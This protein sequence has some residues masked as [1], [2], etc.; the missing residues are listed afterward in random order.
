MPKVSEEHRNAR[1]E[2]ITQAALSCFQQYGYDGTSMSQIIKASGLSA[3]AIYSYF[4]SKADI[5]QAV[6]ESIIAS[7]QQGLA[8]LTSGDIK[9]PADIMRSLLEALDTGAAAP[10]L[11]QLWSQAV[12]DD[13]IR[14][15]VDR[16]IDDL[17]DIVSEALERWAQHTNQTTPTSPTWATDSA[18]L[19]TGAA[20]GFIL[21][22]AIQENFDTV[23][24]INTASTW[25]EKANA[26]PQH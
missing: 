10:S 11:V 20:Q 2:T 21:R 4:P 26:L 13:N 5:F 24:Y 17:A 19:F 15:I 12:V 18:A 1:R 8:P 7:R 6:T 3:G 22:K 23:S 9:T 16:F 25:A 14:P